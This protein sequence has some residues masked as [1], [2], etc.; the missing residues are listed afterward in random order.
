MSPEPDG[1]MAHIG[2]RM[3]ELE[4]RV[5]RM[6]EQI[7]SRLSGLSAKI[8]Q[9]GFVRSDVYLAERKADERELDEVDKRAMWAI[10]LVCAVT[11][12]AIITAILSTA[13]VFA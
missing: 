7:E 13:G 4:K 8:D 10:G 1:G 6:G 2:W 9:L 5:E 11:I 3:E 12:G